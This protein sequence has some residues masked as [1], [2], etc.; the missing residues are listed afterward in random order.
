M[1]ILSVTSPRD[2]CQQIVS[3]S[4]RVH[5]A[6]RLFSNRS[7]MTSKYGT[8]KKVAHEPLDECVTDVFTTCWR[9]R[10][11]ITEQALGNIEHICIIQQR[12]EKVTSDVIYASVLRYIATDRNERRI[13]CWTVG[14]FSCN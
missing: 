2:I 3:L 11:C 6:M 7:Q 5:V 13:D 1:K 9:R 4:S 12:S 14:T 10:W 8:H